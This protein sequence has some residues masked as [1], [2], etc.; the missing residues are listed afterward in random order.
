MSQSPGRAAV[1]QAQASLFSPS[2]W[3]R[4]AEELR[5]YSHS[6][7][8]KSTSRKFQ[9]NMAAI[10]ETEATFERAA[11]RERT[12][13]MARGFHTP[14]TS[15]LSYAFLRSATGCFAYDSYKSTSTLMLEFR[16]LWRVRSFGSNRANL[17]GSQPVQ[18]FHLLCPYSSAIRQPLFVDT[19]RLAP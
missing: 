19:L 6:N 12:K 1:L 17:P 4:S 8:A 5:G 3:K 2:S 7:P 9:K 18:A 16:A 14:C 10:D 11:R 15:S 13:F